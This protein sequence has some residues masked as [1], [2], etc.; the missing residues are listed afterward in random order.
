MQ[1]PPAT[2][3][4]IDPSFGYRLPDGIGLTYPIEA[5]TNL[6]EWTP[7]TNALFYFRDPEST[8]YPQRFYRF[9]KN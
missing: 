7:L 8:N 4:A 6:V 5:S 2:P 3:L 1:T 9:P